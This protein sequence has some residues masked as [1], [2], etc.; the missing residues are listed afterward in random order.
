[1]NALLCFD[2]VVMVQEHCGHFASLNIMSAF[3]NGDFQKLDQIMQSY[4][5]ISVRL[6]TF[7]VVFYF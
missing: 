6:T 7:T 3:H 4:L 5:C 1:M 2:D